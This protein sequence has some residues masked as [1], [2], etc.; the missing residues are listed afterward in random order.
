MSLSLKDINAKYDNRVDLWVSFLN[1]Y[2]QKS[3]AEIGVYKGEFAEEILRRCPGIQ[4]YTMIDAWRNL[5][6]W[7]KPANTDND[8]FN[9]F[10]NETIARTK[11]A[12]NKIKVLKGKTTEVVNLIPDE[13]LDFVYI[14]GDHTLKGIVVDLIS[15]WEKVK[16]D[17][18][19]AGDDFCESIWQHQSNFEP[20]LVFPLAIYFA[21]A[22][23]AK[24]YGLSHNQFLI[25]KNEKGFEFI[26][27]TKKCYD[28]ISLLNQ[29]NKKERTKRRGLTSW[30]RFFKSKVLSE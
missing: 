26:N 22:K 20:T 1:D 21:E 30:S 19:I 25:A 12:E 14:D 9:E 16:P 23:N 6:E 24:I 10:Y 17:G 29:I 4:R 28:N 18:Y 13:S 8:T 2:H 5:A 15:L 3:V 7:N 11:F 27:L